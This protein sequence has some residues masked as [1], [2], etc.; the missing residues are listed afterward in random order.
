MANNWAA[1]DAAHRGAGVKTAVVSPGRHK[2]TSGGKHLGNIE[3][4]GDKHVAVV[5]ADRGLQSKEFGSH[6]EAL[7]H[8]RTEHGLSHAS[9][10]KLPASKVPAAPKK[11]SASKPAPAWSQWDAE[12]GSGGGG[13]SSADRIAA[14]IHGSLGHASAPGAPKTTEMR[15]R[16]KNRSVVSQGALSTSTASHATKSGFKRLAPVKGEKNQFDSAQ[17]KI[18]MA[19]YNRKKKAAVAHDP[20]DQK[21]PDT[22]IRVNPHKTSGSASAD[23]IAA[24]IRAVHAEHKASAPP[25]APKYEPG[26]HEDLADKAEAATKTAREQNTKVSHLSAADM[27]KDA[28][29]THGASESKAYTYHSQM[30]AY[31]KA[32]A[33][34]PSTLINPGVSEEH[35][36]EQHSRFPSGLHQMLSSFMDTLSRRRS[37]KMY[38]SVPE[39]S[40]TGLLAHEKTAVRNY[41]GSSYSS[42]NGHLRGTSPASGSNLH[43][44][45][46]VTAGLDSAFE[47]Q[48]GLK[49]DLVTYRGVKKAGDMFGPVG[50]KVGGEFQDL[51]Y[52]STASHA[53][54]TRGFGASG[55]ALIRVLHP[56]GSKLMRPSTVGS[57]GDAERELLVPRGVRF[58]VAADR[59][60][61]TNNGEIMRQIDLIRK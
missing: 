51:G 40:A 41:T 18:R 43:H 24:A 6:E 4:R 28:G 9:V 2:V 55:G 61:T 8:I 7:N 53:A 52:G 42:V 19:E 50:S 60:V 16:G 33:H 25:P 36:D 46:G 17:T 1:W 47:K 30:A 31:H 26:S 38:E 57:F 21:T 13:V 45:D 5:K 35:K 44:V 48:P 12:H 56:A 59:M 29:S 49:Q 20:V 10:P 54:I 14:Q 3:K 32:A 27:H 37:Q 23:R 39:A 22:E 15:G 58:H 11:S 34:S